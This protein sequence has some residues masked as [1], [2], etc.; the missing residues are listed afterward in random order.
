MEENVKNSGHFFHKTLMFMKNPNLN[1]STTKKDFFSSVKSIW[2]LFKST[3]ISELETCFFET[4]EP[5]LSNI[6]ESIFSAKKVRKKA[7]IDN[8]RILFKNGFGST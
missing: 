5:I 8:I 2:F 4:N 6:Q 3:L 1:I 7:K